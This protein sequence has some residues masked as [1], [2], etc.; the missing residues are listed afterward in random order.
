MIQKEYINI[1]VTNLVN[2][3][4]KSL[5]DKHN[6]FINKI[7]HEIIK[8]VSNKLN[9]CDDY[10]YETYDVKNDH[11][12]DNEKVIYYRKKQDNSSAN[13]F[14]QRICNNGSVPS[15]S[16]IIITNQS[17]IYHKYGVKDAYYTGDSSNLDRCIRILENQELTTIVYD[18]PLQ[19]III[20]IIQ[21][22]LK[23]F[24][25]HHMY[26]YTFGDNVRS[27]EYTSLYHNKILAIVDNLL[28][29]NKKYFYN[30][31]SSVDLQRKY[32]SSLKIINNHEQ[33]IK[34]LNEEK[35]KLREQLK[36]AIP[37][38]NQC[39]ICFGY[40]NKNKVCSPC[41][42]R[43]YCDECIGKIKRCSLCQKDIDNII[44]LY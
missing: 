37:L 23:S 33:T 38:D 11:I 35:N 10:N 24:D 20:T 2:K 34:R 43:Q 4:I 31:M 27:N 19:P 32:E 28:Q 39:C 8:D 26:M 3:C 42:H 1:H 22:T 44:N 14:K 15:I 12:Q 40:T 29:I 5:N 25:N 13:V 6:D 41:G 36:N 18:T 21:S 7:S 17:N 9:I 16:E 30:F